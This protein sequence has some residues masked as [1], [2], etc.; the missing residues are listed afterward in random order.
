MLSWGIIIFWGLIVA[1]GSIIVYLIY[2]V[3]K[4]FGVIREKS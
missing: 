2:E 1:L 3:F 4:E